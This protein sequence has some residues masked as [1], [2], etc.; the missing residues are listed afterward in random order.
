MSV[1]LTVQSA[2]N[3]LSQYSVLEIYRLIFHYLLEYRIEMNCKI[4]PADFDSWKHHSEMP[5]DLGIEWVMISKCL[6]L[7]LDLLTRGNQYRRRRHITNITETDP[8]PS[9]RLCTRI[10]SFIILKPLS[11]LYHAQICRFWSYILEKL[12]I[13]VN[14]C[15]SFPLDLATTVG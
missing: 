2:G 15:A 1:K 7:P 6:F 4:L 12:M 3:I 9:R 8:V 5:T 11:Y 10:T 14:I 13:S